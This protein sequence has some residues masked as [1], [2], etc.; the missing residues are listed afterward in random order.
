MTIS[1]IGYL[2][3]LKDIQTRYGKTLI[4]VTYNLT[5]GCSVE[6]T[7]ESHPNLPC[8]LALKMSSSL[9]LV[10]E[11]FKYGTDFY[12][13]GGITNN[14]PIDVADKRGERILGITLSPDTEHAV[15]DNYSNI[16]EYIYTLI[17]IPIKQSISHR[18]DNCS[19]KC[20][21]VKLKHGDLN[22]L[23]LVF[24]LKKNLKC[25][26]AGINK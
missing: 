5:K 21:I 17:Y 26:Q 18:I 20:T 11:K 3:T 7:P 24:L 9:P 16:L 25:F 15:G 23:T 8:I 10:F 4:C 6:L 13:D 19:E 1:K 22:F 14:F 2:P 12:I